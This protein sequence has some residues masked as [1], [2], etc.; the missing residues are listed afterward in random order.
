EAA[1]WLRSGEI[2]TLFASCFTST[3]SARDRVF[4]VLVRFTPVAF[5]FDDA[6]SLRALEEHSGL[7]S[8]TIIGGR[9]IKAVDRRHPTQSRAH[10]VL[11]TT[12]AEAANS[13]ISG[14]VVILDCLVEVEKFKKEPVKCSRCHHYGHMV[15]SCKSSADVCGSCGG[16]HRSF[17]CTA[18][19]TVHCVSCNS[20]SHAS[21]DRHCPTFL[22]LCDDYDMRNPD[23]AMP[24]Y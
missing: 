24:F 3:A 12:S 22:Q 23:N 21:S 9:W 8:G 16:A 4:P 2:C 18:Y 6:A 11:Y 13:L 19:K 14:N 15:A 1:D 20:D 7:G 17:K 5:D 10:C